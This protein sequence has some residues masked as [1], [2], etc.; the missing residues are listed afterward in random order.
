[1]PD[2]EHPRDLTE[3]I[4]WLKLNY[5]DPLMVDCSD[6]IRVQDYAH[7]VTGQ[8]LG[9]RILH[10]GLKADDI[11]PEVIREDCFALKVNHDSGGVLVCRDR[12]SFNWD[13]ARAFM[14]ARVRRNFYWE[15]RETAYWPL[16][17]E[18][19]VEECLPETET[20]PL[21]DHKFFCFN[22]VPRVIQMLRL[23]Y[24]DR[25]GELRK[26]HLFFDPDWTR[27]PIRRNYPAYDG[28]MPRPDLS[29]AMVAL[30]RKLAAPFPLVRVD[31]Y[32][33]PGTGRLYLG[34]MTFYPSA[35]VVRF[36]PPD[37][38]R[39]AGDWLTLPEKHDPWAVL[40]GYRPGD[41]VRRL[42]AGASVPGP[43]P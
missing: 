22:G 13:G 16:K 41:A 5:L 7:A 11:R 39:E 34:E 37:F 10:R 15:H 27:L 28:D 26:R 1:M 32:A 36:E 2:L 17:P 18:I 29:E 30:A 42:A 8:D 20:E 43:A 31:L 21:L 9:A 4:A 14:A 35:G 33:P 23:E 38:E 6:K 24:G 12:A 40:R 19:F 3:K 25:P